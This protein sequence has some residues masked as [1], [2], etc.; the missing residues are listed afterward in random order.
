MEKRDF[1]AAVGSLLGMARALRDTMQSVRDHG[2]AARDLERLV[3][4]AKA[5]EGLLARAKVPEGAFSGS[6]LGLGYT[7]IEHHVYGAIS[8]SKGPA[9]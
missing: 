5:L 9:P 6:D 7:S 8:A 1:D 4:N 2:D 3:S